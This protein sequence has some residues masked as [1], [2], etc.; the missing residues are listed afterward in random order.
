MRRLLAAAV[1]TVLALTTPTPGSAQVSGV[2]LAA[3]SGGDAWNGFF[4]PFK[5]TPTGVTIKYVVLCYDTAT[6]EKFP[7][8]VDVPIPDGSTLAQMRT[9]ATTAVV[10]GCAEYGVTVP[11]GAV[12]LP[13]IQFGS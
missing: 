2:A 8:D 6:R 3:L 12:L 4:G 5:P 7:R 1:L 10:D 11:R 9:L 13:S